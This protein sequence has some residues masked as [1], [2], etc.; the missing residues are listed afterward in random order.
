MPLVP[1]DEH[2]DGI[3]IVIKHPGAGEGLTDLPW[4]I[5]CGLGGHPIMCPSVLLGV[6][7]DEATATTGQL[8]FLA[9]SHGTTATHLGPE[10]L[11]R[12]EYPTVAV[13]TAPGDVT[14]HLGDTLHLAPPPSG[15]SGPGR[16]A[17]YAVWGNPLQ[18]ELL[19]PRTGY[20]D[21]VLRSGQGNRVRTVD[22][23]LKVG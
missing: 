16:R 3:S 13:T 7:L 1:I 20:N 4:H 23:Q 15:T 6:Q 9:G 18:V 22:E 2:N 12:P 14:V 8:H 17:V 19:P 5:D 21:L 10:V 11:G